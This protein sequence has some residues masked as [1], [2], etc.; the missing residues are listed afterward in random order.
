MLNVYNMC[1]TLLI[2]S[3]CIINLSPFSHDSVHETKVTQQI[4][5]FI[6]PLSQQLYVHHKTRLGSTCRVSVVLGDP[7]DP[8][9]VVSHLGVDTREVSIGTADAPRHNTLKFTITYKRS[10][11]VPLEKQQKGETL[12]PINFKLMVAVSFSM[13]VRI[14]LSSDVYLEF[15][16]F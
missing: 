5:P 12:A 9:N 16:Q 1:Q 11:R 15:F 14:Y 8:F 10:S 6:R 2:F 13:M 7:V 3:V 4:L